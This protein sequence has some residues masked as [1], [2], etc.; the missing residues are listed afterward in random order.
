M[1]AK[2]LRYIYKQIYL[3]QYYLYKKILIL[4]FYS[5]DI[6]FKHFLLFLKP[7]IFVYIYVINYIK[8]LLIFYIHKLLNTKYQIQRSHTNIYLHPRLLMILTYFLTNL[9]SVLNIELNSHIHY[10]P[11]SIIPLITT[12]SPL[13]VYNLDH[14]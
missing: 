3:F 14:N 1:L 8:K 10:Y 12:H 9:H 2:L 11:A 5:F 13:H 7:K 4:Y 6:L